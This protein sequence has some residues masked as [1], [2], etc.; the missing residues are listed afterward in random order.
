MT[1]VLLVDDLRDF[2]SH[3]VN[4]TV[5]VA[6]TSAQA[7]GILAHETTWDEV[8]LD[9]DLGEVDG[10]VDSIMRV[11]DHLCELA[12]TDQT[13]NI[14]LIRVHTSN[15]VGGETMVRT[16]SRYGYWVERVDA[17]RY[18]TAAVVD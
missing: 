15:P 9:H 10:E 18:L 5:V 2:R 17:G 3:P 8:W 6:R 16:L 12:Y 11:V 14:G 1:Q 13:V 4:V 7:L